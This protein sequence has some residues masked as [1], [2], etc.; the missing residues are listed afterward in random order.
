LR[1]EFRPNRS[2]LQSN[3]KDMKNKTKQNKTK[4]NKTK[5]INKLSSKSPYSS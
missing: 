5:K 2:K 1:N 4:Q 3:D